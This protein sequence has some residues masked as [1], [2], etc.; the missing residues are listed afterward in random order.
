MFRY[1]GRAATFF[2][3]VCD[4]EEEDQ[5]ETR[6]LYFSLFLIIILFFFSPDD[7]TCAERFSFSFVSFVALAISSKIATKRYIYRERE[8][9]CGRQESY[10]RWPQIPRTG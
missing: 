3:V 6:L 7:D 1:L 9:A 4:K 8:S 5:E 2:Y 10:N